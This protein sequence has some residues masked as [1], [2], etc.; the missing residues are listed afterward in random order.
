MNQI[1]ILPG[2]QSLEYS[3]WISCTG[4]NHPLTKK[5]KKSF[6]QSAGVVKYTDCTSAEGSTPTTTTTHTHTNECPGYDSKQSGGGIPVMLELWEMQSTCSL[7]SFPGPL[8]SRV[9]APDR[10]LFMGQIEQKCIL[11]LNW[12]AWNRTVFEIEIVLML[13]WLFELKL[14]D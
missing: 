11:M 1:W 2:L 12:I 13:N 6:A 8:W 7:P 5:K 9:V 3:H 10:V 4:V 14:F